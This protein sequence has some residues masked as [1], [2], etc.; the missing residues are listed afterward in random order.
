MFKN[1]ISQR[2]LSLD[3][4]HT[5]HRVAQTGGIARAANSNPVQQ[6][7]FSRQIR[8]L[9]SFFGVELTLRHGKGIRL[10]P[11]GEELARL[12][13]Q[14]LTGLSDFLHS[15]QK[16]P[17]HLVLGAGDSFLQWL[18]LPKLGRIQKEFPN[19]ELEL[20][21]L[22][23]RYVLE[24]VR[25]QNLDFGIV[26]S[27]AVKK[28]L[29]HRSLG[30]H[31]FSLFVPTR[32][33]RGHS[34]PQ[35]GAWLSQL[36]LAVQGGKEGAVQQMLGR[37]AKKLGLPLNIR[38]QCESFPEAAEALRSGGYAAILPDFARSRLM[39]ADVTEMSLSGLKGER[40]HISLVWNPRTFSIRPV[41]A[42]LQAVF[43]REFQLKP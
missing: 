34:Q 31:G 37:V 29:E 9:E 24:G 23:N 28:P 4:L 43:L 30:S 25:N 32:L 11:Q 21:N 42:K 36:P 12:I 19:V 10:T 20:I 15:C 38:L 5:F 39:E 41:T 40:S 33:K 26:R 16:L 3:R 2:G 14:Q 6:S 8:E 13:Q 35:S 18:V 27:S 7:Q 1:L 22:Q 17:I